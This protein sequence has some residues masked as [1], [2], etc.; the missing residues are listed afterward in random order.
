MESK[1]KIYYKISGKDY[2]MLFY[3]DVNSDKLEGLIEET[4]SNDK[5]VLQ[6]HMS[7]SCY[8]NA[9]SNPLAVSLIRKAKEVTKE[10]YDTANSIIDAMV[11]NT[12]WL[13]AENDKEVVLEPTYA[14]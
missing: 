13:I 10:E 1:E 6:K 8:N 7:A 3:Y 12:D 4:K 14:D 9:I 2:I 11:N 5:L